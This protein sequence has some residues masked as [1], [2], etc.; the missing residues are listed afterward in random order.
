MT[1]E[2]NKWKTTHRHYGV[3]TH[4]ALSNIAVVPPGDIPSI[5]QRRRVDSHFRSKSETRGLEEVEKRSGRRRGNAAGREH[6]G[7]RE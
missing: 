6:A 3:T 1:S 5:T 2:A 7:D 4:F